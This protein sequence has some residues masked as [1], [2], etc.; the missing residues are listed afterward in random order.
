MALTLKERQVF[1]FWQF[2][3][4]GRRPTSVVV[5]PA[6]VTTR[7][8][9]LAVVMFCKGDGWEVWNVKIQMQDDDQRSNPASEGAKG[10]LTPTSW[11][12]IM[13]N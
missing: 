13:T 6:I 10:L 9:M 11:Y 1:F 2:P 3:G 8:S 7:A 12:L 5:R 4:R